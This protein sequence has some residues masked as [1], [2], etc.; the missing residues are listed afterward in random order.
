MQA[1]QRF[2]D[3]YDKETTPSVVEYA[4]SSVVDEGLLNVTTALRTKK[5]WELTLMVVSSDNGGPAFSDQ[6]AASNF[7][8]R[9]GKYT[10]F[11]GGLRT[12]A[13]VTGGVLPAAMRGVNVS[14]PIHICDWC[15]LAARLAPA[16][17]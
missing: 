10:Y 4:F 2:K 17:A 12:T 3:L 16:A 13:F 9:G 1:P 14:A 15:A 5:M 11:E 8:L 7:P 6:Q